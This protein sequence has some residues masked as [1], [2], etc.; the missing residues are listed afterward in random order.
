MEPLE[1]TL[2]RPGPSW[3]FVAVVAHDESGDN[4]IGFH[5]IW[6]NLFVHSSSTFDPVTVKA[7]GANYRVSAEADEDGMVT[8]TVNSAANANEEVDPDLRDK[9]IYASG[10]RLQT[11][12]GIFDRPT[13]ASLPVTSMQVPYSLASPSSNTLLKA[14]GNHYSDAV[15]ETGLA[16]A[17]SAGE[18]I[19]P[20]A[21]E[22]L[23]LN[24]A[25]AASA[26][27]ASLAS[28]WSMLQQ[29][30]E[31]GERL[32]FTEAFALQSKIAYA[33]SIISPAVTAGKI[34][35]A[36]RAA[37]MGWE[38]PGVQE[39]VDS[40]SAEA[41]CRNAGTALHSV[42]QSAGVADVDGLLAQ[43][44]EVHTALP[45]HGMAI[46]AAPP[47]NHRPAKANR[48]CRRIR[49]SCPRHSATK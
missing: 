47:E 1:I 28:S 14:F 5:G 27:Y 23:T 25:E 44:V 19:S 18:A 26:H 45:V 31:G 15:D 37:D 32:S 39:M 21:M 12:D 11:L 36:A 8:T 35:R 10:V 16:E 3:V 49:C 24:L 42:L 29:W 43:D 33:E 7:D 17:L 40:L 20:I 13:I 2:R 48:Y 38:D 4:E 30:I 9:A 6:Q 34:I 22:A 46:D 41:T